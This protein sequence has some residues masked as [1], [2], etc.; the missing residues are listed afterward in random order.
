MQTAVGALQFLLV[1]YWLTLLSRLVFNVVQTYSPEVKPRGFGLVFIEFVLT[2]TD[3]PV[4]A[5]RSV[6]PPIKAGA[7]QI[8]LS[9]L[10]LMVL[11]WI[12]YGALDLIQT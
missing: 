8:D 2:V 1:L 9:L 10:I 5:V 11:V 3:P 4:R 12:V 6:V 7:V